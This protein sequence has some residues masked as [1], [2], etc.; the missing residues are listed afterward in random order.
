MTNV[1]D[2]KKIWKNKRK[3]GGEMNEKSLNFL[4]A[5][6]LIVIVFT[7]LLL[8]VTRMLCIDLP[9]LIVRVLGFATI[10]ALPVFVFSNIKRIQKV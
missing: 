9:E 5:V 6:S 7:A 4:W 8:L 3:A 2:H 10:I 1:Q